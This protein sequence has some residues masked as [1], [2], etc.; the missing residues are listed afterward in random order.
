MGHHVIM[1]F[2][3]GTLWQFAIS[4][5]RDA[6]RVHGQPVPLMAD[7]VEPTRED[8]D[9]FREIARLWNA[10]SG[11]LKMDY[12]L[13]PGD[14]LYPEGPLTG[15]GARDVTLS[16]AIRESIGRTVS[17][18]EFRGEA[19]RMIATLQGRVLHAAEAVAGQSRLRV[20]VQFPDGS[21]A[22]FVIDKDHTL[23]AEYE[24]GSARDSEGNIV[25]DQSHAEGQQNHSNLE[26]QHRFTDATNAR[27]W[28]DRARS[29]GIPIV[30]SRNGNSGRP[31]LVNCIWENGKMKCVARFASI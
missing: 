23:Q 7:P 10:N 22:V 2:R 29:L 30:D 18:L 25:P 11:S 14:P 1:D 27:E 9:Q 6:Y 17:T 5:D 26:G 28:I 12:A 15:F 31:I 16:V 8:I 20:I 13:R 3:Y 21:S 24:M 19:A 4:V